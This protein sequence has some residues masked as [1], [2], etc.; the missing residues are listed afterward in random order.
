MQYYLTWQ[1]GVIVAGQLIFVASAEMYK[2]W[3]RRAA[4]WNPPRA[5]P[6]GVH[7]GEGDEPPH[8]L[9]DEG[10]VKFESRTESITSLERRARQSDLELQS[11]GLAKLTTADGRGIVND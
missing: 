1:W 9:E 6:S 5:T 10:F 2:L 11:A 4:W 7:L 8:E 3:K